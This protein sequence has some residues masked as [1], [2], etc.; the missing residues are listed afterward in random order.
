M[1]NSREETFGEAGGWMDG[2]MDGWMYVWTCIHFVKRRK[3]NMHTTW[4]TIQILR[5]RSCEETWG[6]KRKM[7]RSQKY[8]NAD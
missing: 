6:T 4:K 8:N 1:S 3:R 2:W 7:E 5:I